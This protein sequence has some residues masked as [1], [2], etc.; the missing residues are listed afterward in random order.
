M[1]KDQL[2]EELAYRGKLT[3]RMATQVIEHLAN[4]VIEQVREGNKVQITGFGTFDLGFRAA[5][6]GVDPQ[7]H[8][9]IQIPKMAMPRFRAG[10]RLKEEVREHA[11]V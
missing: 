5:R 2:S 3:K 9:E 11:K 8:Q 7:T 1:T 10:K 6:R 4:V